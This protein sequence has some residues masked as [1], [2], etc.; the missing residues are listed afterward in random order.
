MSP[1]YL[2]VSRIVMLSAA[3]ALAG[4]V[5]EDYQHSVQTSQLGA[6]EYTPAVYVE[7]GNELRYQKVLALCRQ[8]AKK[9][10]LTASQ[11]AELRAQTGMTD[12][13]AQGALGGLADS[14]FSGGDVGGATVAGGLIGLFGSAITE[15]GKGTVATAAA[16]RHALLNCLKATSRGGALWSVV[17]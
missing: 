2:V 13:A 12:A 3:V 8:V 14:I 1:I 9:R 5:A 10:E 16:T 17:E 7:P 4:C 15:S 11:Q 6:Q